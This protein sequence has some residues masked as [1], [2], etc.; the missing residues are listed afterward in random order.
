L[1]WADTTNDESNGEI[2]KIFDAANGLKK[3]STGAPTHKGFPIFESEQKPLAPNNTADPKNKNIREFGTDAVGLGGKAAPVS[4]RL[5]KTNIE[6]FRGGI[7]GT[8]AKYKD[9]VDS[10][11]LRGFQPGDVNVNATVSTVGGAGAHDI[12]TNDK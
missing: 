9:E 10:K 4:A 7:F 1:I 6:Q 2:G 12:S 3:S 5:S 8:D 11:K